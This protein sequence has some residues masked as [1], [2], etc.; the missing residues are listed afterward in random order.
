MHYGKQSTRLVP[1]AVSANHGFHPEDERCDWCEPPKQ[2]TVSVAFRGTAPSRETERQAWLSHH[3]GLWSIYSLERLAKW[4]YGVNAY[5]I[6]LSNGSTT[7]CLTSDGNS[8][9]REFYNDGDPQARDQKRAQI[10]E[11]II[12]A[13]RLRNP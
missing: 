5:Y 1:C 6:E 10:A 4:V 8:R 12:D 11:Y 7:T 13:D 2:V 9:W 3:A